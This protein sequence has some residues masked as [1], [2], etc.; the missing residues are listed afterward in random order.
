MSLAFMCQWGSEHGRQFIKTQF[1]VKSI[2]SSVVDRLTCVCL[3]RYVHPTSALQQAFES[4]NGH[5]LEWGL[6]EL[7]PNRYAINCTTK[8]SCVKT[9]QSIQQ[10][11]MVHKCLQLQV[12]QKDVESFPIVNIFWQLTL[13]QRYTSIERVAH[14]QALSAIIDGFSNNAC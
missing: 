6:F 3:Q 4:M 10:S 14:L 2:I 8:F 12:W 5:G 7:L 11:S 13:G 1:C 9:Q